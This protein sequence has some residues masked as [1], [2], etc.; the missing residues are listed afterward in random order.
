[1]SVPFEF[2]RYIIGQKGREVQSLKDEYDVNILVPARDKMVRDN[3][4]D[5]G[6][7]GERERERERE[8]GMNE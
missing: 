1:M 7:E 3:E 6:R 2:R 5:G 8:R 4:E